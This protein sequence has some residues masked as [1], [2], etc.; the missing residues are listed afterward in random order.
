MDEVGVNCCWGKHLRSF[1]T[2]LRNGT[3]DP[4][5]LVLCSPPSTNCNQARSVQLNVSVYYTHLWAVSACESSWTESILARI[6]FEACVKATAGEPE[7][8]NFLACLP[9]NFEAAGP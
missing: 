2:Q 7:D 9:P 8:R 1:G 4:S 3:S 5:R 6:A